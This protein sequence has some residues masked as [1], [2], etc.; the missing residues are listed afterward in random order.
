MITFQEA[1]VQAGAG[2]K[3]LLLG[4]GFSINYFSYST[5]LDQAGLEASSPLRVLF[6]ELNTVDFERVMRSLSAHGFKVL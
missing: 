3:S 5:L 2:S 4:N 1:I 6:S